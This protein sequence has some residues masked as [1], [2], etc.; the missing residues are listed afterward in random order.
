MTVAVIL[1]LS[2]TQYP[3]NKKEVFRVSRIARPPQKRGPEP[4]APVGGGINTGGQG[5]CL[6]RPGL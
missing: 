2:L 5:Q 1:S 4:R 3:C 6:G